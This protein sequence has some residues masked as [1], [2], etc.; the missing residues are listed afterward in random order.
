MTP[1]FHLGWF[2]VLLGDLLVLRTFT[3]VRL[4]MM[5]SIGCQQLHMLEQK[6]KNKYA[7][8]FPDNTHQ[9]NHD[10]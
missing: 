1:C 7:H 8:A 6:C 10:G 5:H 2:D 3:C 9:A 4:T